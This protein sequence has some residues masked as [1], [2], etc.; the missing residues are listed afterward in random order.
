MI[1]SLEYDLENSSLDSQ[2]S[3]AKAVSG[4]ESKLHS[5][6]PENAVTSQSLLKTIVVVFGDEK[7]IAPGNTS[8]RY[9]Y[10]DAE[11]TITPTEG[12]ENYLFSLR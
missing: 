3:D 11:S 2:A 8:A 10:A 12:I 5:I 1:D 4:Y 9:V 6:F 7:T